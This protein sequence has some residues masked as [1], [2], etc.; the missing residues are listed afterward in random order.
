MSDQHFS[1]V[2]KT[3]ESFMAENIINNRPRQLFSSKTGLGVLHMVSHCERTSYRISSSFQF[4]G[5]LT[6]KQVQLNH[7]SETR[8][9]CQEQTPY[10][11]TCFHKNYHHRCHQLKTLELKKSRSSWRYTCSCIC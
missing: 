8:I 11:C 5:C 3:T 6:N 2:E 1:L 9:I 10:I 4:V 7:S